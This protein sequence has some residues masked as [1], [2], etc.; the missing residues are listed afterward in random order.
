[1]LYDVDV[2]NTAHCCRISGS[3]RG[4]RAHAD[5]RDHDAAYRVYRPV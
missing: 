5:S 4:R 3:P 2:P 1:L